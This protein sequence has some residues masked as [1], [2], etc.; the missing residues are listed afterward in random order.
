MAAQEELMVEKGLMGYRQLI[1]E[2]IRQC[3][4]RASGTL[5]F[6][7]DNGQSARLVLNQGSICWVAF[8]QLRG[9]AALEAIREIGFARFNFNP[10]LKLAIG[11]QRLPSTSTII[12]R[13]YLDARPSQPGRV[14]DIPLM[15]D[16][17]VTSE[18][19]A[20]AGSERRFGLD[21]VR[22]SLECE[23]MEYLGPMARILCADYLKAMPSQ[24]SQAQVRQLIAMLM[25]D[26][27]DEAKGGRFMERV[28][29]AL[30]MP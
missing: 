10:L 2:L 28:K 29:K 9:E 11:E 1:D 26:I 15:T 30:K 18:L 24:L 7:L 3:K 12:K 19:P 14:D 16:V 23:A 25:Q 27:H 4:A 21:Q 5:F 17:V 20:G 6:N 22:Q 13:L 8:R